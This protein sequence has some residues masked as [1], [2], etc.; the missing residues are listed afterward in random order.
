MKMRWAIVSAL[1]SIAA[2]SGTEMSEYKVKALFL[3]N[4]AQ[5]VEWPPSAFKDP[6]APVTVCVLGP[7][8]FDGEL[9]RT[10][11]ARRWRI[12]P[13]FSRLVE[14]RTGSAASPSPG[15]SHGYMD[16]TTNREDWQRDSSSMGHAFQRSEF[17]GRSAKAPLVGG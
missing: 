14:Q 16:Y 1:F 3:Y 2:I 8:P 10:G 4:F 11:K 7:N 13:G 9:E 5:F 15:A 6:A 12:S 17:G